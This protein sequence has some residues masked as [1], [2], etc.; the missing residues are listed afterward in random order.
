M[1]EAQ[2]ESGAQKIIGDFAPKLV[3]LTDD[4]LFGDVWR[5]PELA[6][7]GPQPDHHRRPD[8]RRQHRT[9][10]G[11][12]GHR[13]GERPHRDRAQG[14]DHPPRVLCGLAQGDVR[15]RCRQARLQRLTPLPTAA[16]TSACTAAGRLPF[17]PPVDQR[18]FPRLDSLEV[19]PAR[20]R[21][22][23]GPGGRGPH[24]DGD[25]SGRPH[26]V[27]RL[28]NLLARSCGTR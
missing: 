25:D 16:A 13:E 6:P 23:R 19:S 11:A 24:L 17:R 28:G 21:T 18:G 7:R 15:R 5:R 12:P 22:R 4:V 2:G 1:P 8:H 10:A 26:R 9:A 3:S 14:S 20:A 27:R